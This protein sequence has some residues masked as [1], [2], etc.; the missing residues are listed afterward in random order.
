[1]SDIILSIIISTHNHE[2]YIYSSLNSALKQCDERMEVIIIDN[3][4]SDGTTHEIQRAL[5]NN[6]GSIIKLTAINKA[7]STAKIR[8]IGIDNASGKYLTFLNG[9]DLWLDNFIEVIIPIMEHDAP[10]LID[11]DYINF[12]SEDT[13][14]PARA[15]I[16]DLQQSIHHNNPFILHQRVGHPHRNIWGRVFRKEMLDNYQMHSANSYED[17]FLILWIYLKSCNTISINFSLYLH[18]LSESDITQISHIDTITILTE[19]I[20]YTIREFESHKNH[21]VREK[22][23]RLLIATYFMEIKSAHKEINGFYNYNPKTCD[24]I[25]KS[26]TLVT[27]NE[28]TLPFRLHMKYPELVKTT[29]GL[30]K[31]LKM[32][33]R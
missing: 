19:A 7:S 26:S 5:K 23:L 32:R 14:L 30:L 4:S 24:I 9:D 15:Y 12:R 16:T 11:F 13:G 31:L 10:D 22:L 25:K 2:Q 3:N 29:S 21:V 17:V 28:A 6:K 27:H 20:E 18:R 1:M 33:H 8:N